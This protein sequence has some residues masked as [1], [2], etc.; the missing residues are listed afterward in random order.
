MA[1]SKTPAAAPAQG[2]QDVLDVNLYSRQIYALGQTAMFRL[3]SANVIVSG[4]GSIGVEIAKNLVLGGVRKVTLQDTANVT[5][6]DLSAQY[7]LT[8]ADL[9]KNRAAAC[10]Q[11]VEELND[12][13]TCT[14]STD[15][16][17]AENVAHYDLLIVTDTPFD[18]QVKLNNL[19]RA[20]N[21]LFISADLAGLSGYIFTD[22]GKAFRI[23]DNDGEACKEVHLENINITDGDVTTFDGQLHGFQD[24]DYVSFSELKGCKQLIGHAPIKISVKNK[25]VF[26][27]GDVAKDFEPYIEGGRVKQVKVPFEVSFKSLEESLADPKFLD[28]D[29]LK[30]NASTEL[31]Q[32]FQAL[33]KFTAEKGAR[34]TPYT[35]ADASA[36]AALLPK[37]PE[38]A[39]ESAKIFAYTAAGNLQPVASVIGG[40]AAQ[41]AM[42]AITHYT[43]PQNGFLYIDNVEA[44]PAKIKKNLDGVNP[45][46]FAPKNTRYDAQAAVFGWDFVEKTK[47]F[48]PFIVGAGAIGCELLKN[49]AMMGVATDPSAQ[50]K[51]TDMDQIELSNLNRQFLF[52]RNDVGGKKSECAAAAVKKF[53]SELNI[54]V[55]SDRVAEDTEAVFNDA[56][57]EDLDAVTN[58]LDNLDARRYMDRR[59]VY[60]RLPLLESGT[61][62]TKGNTQV[63]YPHITESYSSSNDPPEK[64]I[65]ICTLKN[66]PYEIQHT[67]Q[68]ARDTF[69]GLFTN[70]AETVNQFVQDE[71]GFLDRIVAMTPNQKI[72][73]LQ[74]VKSALIDEKPT[75]SVQCV[76]WARDLF[77]QLYHNQIAQLLH[78]FPEDQVTTTGVRFWSGTK[79][80]PHPIDYNPE[81]PTHVDFVY[82]AAILRAQQ[83]KLE[84]IFDKATF[85]Q[86]VSTYEV[87]PFQPSSNVKIAA[88]DAEAAA[89]DENAGAVDETDTI[90]NNLTLALA[91]LQTRDELLPIDFEKDDDT[92]YHMEFV[93]ACS[94][95]RAANYNIPAADI[96]H[97]KQ[98]AGRI[99]PA[100]ATTTAVVAGLVGIELYKVI[101]MKGEPDNVDKERFK[102]GF[103]NL[104]LPLYAFSEPLAPPTKEYNNTKFTLWDRIEIQGPMTLQ[105]LLDKIKELTNLEISMMSSGV[106]LLYAFFQSAKARVR[107]VQDVVTAIEAVS[108]TK[109]PE[110]RNSVVLEVSAT[111]DQDE[112]VEIPYIKYNIR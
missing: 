51:I 16:L 96:M 58:A 40:I 49:Y 41:E 88:N 14:L 29:F 86:I 15:A 83:Y 81:D 89:I 22:L 98:I 110:Y 104:A 108:H 26:N 101:D 37:E 3:R 92:N 36:L 2:L 102:C 62:G 106:S 72:Q 57:F 79:R 85:A 61:M 12:S 20:S 95:L 27:I 7:Y 82:S 35:A 60:Y 70:P 78:N 105:A 103:V 8:E 75:D 90:V 93:T 56:F 44:L 68:W 5:Y 19:A 54:T 87:K 50:I 42:K 94:N 111:N 63:V 109:I 34:P 47:K 9:G 39:A 84:P 33:Y 23:D 59:C 13:V 71:R 32:L 46:N 69:G 48:S 53:N 67:I 25:C 76:L 77:Q 100:L 30:F 91:K 107:L 17:T 31:H 55:L 45:E 99:I 65:P 38:V 11:K 43:T 97:T 80:C 73:V 64:D 74:S 21:T 66:F 10:F 24:G 112:D 52:R 28:W 4:L 18:E 1:D 6:T